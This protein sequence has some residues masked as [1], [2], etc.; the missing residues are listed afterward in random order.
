MIYL[1]WA[2]A[3]V[4]LL[5]WLLA[6]G[7]AFVTSGWIHLLLLGAILAIAATLFTPSRTA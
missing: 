1:I 7:G 4:L 5:L 6:V 3:G 2:V